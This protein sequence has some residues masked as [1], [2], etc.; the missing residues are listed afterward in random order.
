MQKLG[1][2]QQTLRVA[3]STRYLAQ[4]IVIQGNML[5]MTIA[6]MLHGLRKRKLDFP[7]NPKT[8]LEALHVTPIKKFLT[9]IRIHFVLDKCLTRALENTVRSVHVI[10]GMQ[11]LVDGLSL[12]K[13][14]VQ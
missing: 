14:L 8:I 1:V 11:F 6:I 2:T 3:F 4:E 5:V 10:V 12:F 7:T 9:G 13:D